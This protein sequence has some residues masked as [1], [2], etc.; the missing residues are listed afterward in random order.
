MGKN[1]FLYFGTLT[2][3]QQLNDLMHKYAQRN[4]IP[5]EESWVELD[6]RYYRRHNIAIFVERKR[7][8]EKT[9]MRL[10]IT[11]FL[12]LTGRLTAAIEIGHEMTD[13]IPME[14]HHAL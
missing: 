1:E 8:R 3:R 13:G 4:H 6:H 2:P 11:E 9:N 7:H 14:K 5:Y 12:D 10:S